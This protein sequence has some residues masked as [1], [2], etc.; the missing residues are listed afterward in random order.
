[1]NKMAIIS[2]NLL[3]TSYDNPEEF[4]K[5]SMDASNDLL[6]Q[7]TWSKTCEDEIKAIKNI[8]K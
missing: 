4:K 8:V 3:R 7:F 5:L 1:M 2:L 6:N